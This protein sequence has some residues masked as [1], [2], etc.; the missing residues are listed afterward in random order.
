MAKVGFVKIRRL[1]VEKVA[2]Q[3]KFKNSTRTAKKTL[4]F[5]IKI[6]WKILFWET[7]AVYTK[8]LT[9]PISKKCRY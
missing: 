8:N 2:R 9:K 4:H 7:I 3:K 6:N 5:T 1:E